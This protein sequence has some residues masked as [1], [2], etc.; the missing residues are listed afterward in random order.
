MHYSYFRILI[1]GDEDKLELHTIVWLSCDLI[2]SRLLP[3]HFLINPVNFF[4]KLVS[5]LQN[6][7]HI[8]NLRLQKNFQYK[9]SYFNN[10]STKEHN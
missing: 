5:D 1:D 2:L 7:Y 9:N 10:K 6:L 3:T 4:V 8:D